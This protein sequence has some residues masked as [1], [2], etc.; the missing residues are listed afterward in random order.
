MIGMA[1]VGLLSLLAL[2]LVIR[3]VVPVTNKIFSKI[4]MDPSARQKE[5]L[6]QRIKEL[7]V[8]GEI[9]REVSTMMAAA[10]RNVTEEEL[11]EVAE[12]VSIN[13]F[14]ALASGRKSVLGVLSSGIERAIKKG[15][16]YQA[17]IEND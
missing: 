3:H 2:V 4:W 10:E 11:M 9:P 6:R 13:D 5:E 1:A 8:N 12:L 16:R 17:R 15:A 14:K 7:Y